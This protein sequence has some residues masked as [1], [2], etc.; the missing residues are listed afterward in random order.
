M[1]TMFAIVA[2]ALVSLGFILGTQRAAVS[3]SATAA[4]T[5][6]MTVVA[7]TPAPWSVDWTQIA[8]V[9][10]ETSYSVGALAVVG[11]TLSIPLTA[12]EVSTKTTTLKATF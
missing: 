1:K 4:E 12:V 10:D 7:P 6:M 8:P 11:R 5:N 2:L 9:K 3:Q